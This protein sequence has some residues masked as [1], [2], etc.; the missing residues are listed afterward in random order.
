M[1]SFNLMRVI[2]ATTFPLR[3]QISFLATS[4]EEVT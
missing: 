4:E 3:L 2:I 1:L